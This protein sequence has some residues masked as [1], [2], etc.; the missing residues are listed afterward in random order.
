MTLADWGGENVRLTPR[1]S[2]S[3]IDS[4]TVSILR[5]KFFVNDRM[6]KSVVHIARTQLTGSPP[7]NSSGKHEI[8]FSTSI[9]PSPNPV[10]SSYLAEND[11]TYIPLFLLLCC[12]FRFATLLLHHLPARL[13]RNCSSCRCV[14]RVRHFLFGCFGQ[15]GLVCVGVG[16]G[17]FLYGGQSSS[18]VFLCSLSISAIHSRTNK[19]NSTCPSLCHL[20]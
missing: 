11:R 10:N 7:L 20:K 12:Q 4:T 5:R 1:P 3:I 9:Y 8:V 2:L 15:C 6:K 18:S 17:R 13:A 16:S 19:Q 14:G